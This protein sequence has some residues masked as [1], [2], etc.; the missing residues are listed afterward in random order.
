MADRDARAPES[1]D[2]FLLLLGDWIVSSGRHLVQG[3]RENGP[4]SFSGPRLSGHRRR[5]AVRGEDE[6][7]C[8]Y[9]TLT[10]AAQGESG[11]S[12]L[13]SQGRQNGRFVTGTDCVGFRSTSRLRNNARVQS[14]GIKCGKTRAASVARSRVTSAPLVCCS[15]PITETDADVLFPILTDLRLYGFTRQRPPANLAELQTYPAQTRWRSSVRTRSSSARGGISMS[16]GG[17]AKRV[18]VKR[19]KSRLLLSEDGSSGSSSCR[20]GQA[21]RSAVI[22]EIAPED[23]HES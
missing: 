2:G 17:E 10:G 7:I 16:G 21:A 11:Q 6:A 13:V 5:I 19:W 4:P 3:R 20:D 9:T 22:G 8:S 1:P 14:G 12:S 15:C 23:L 18:L